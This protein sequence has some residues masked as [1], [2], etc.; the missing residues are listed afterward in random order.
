MQQQTPRFLLFYQNPISRGIISGRWGSG[1]GREVLPQ[2]P[3]SR[4]KVNAH[5]RMIFGMIIK[6]REYLE[7]NHLYL[8]EKSEN[9]SFLA[10]GGYRCYLE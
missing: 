3:I 10:Y 6:E 2:V 9:R 8:I 5:F 4:H 1:T 7:V